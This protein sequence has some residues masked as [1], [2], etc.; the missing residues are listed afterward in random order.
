MSC[1]MAAEFSMLIVDVLVIIA[2]FTA[3]FISGDVL[4]T[5]GM[6]YSGDVSGTLI[7]KIHPYSWI[8]AAIILT[9]LFSGKN[10]WSAPGM[11]VRKVVIGQCIVLVIMIGV[12]L[13][14]GVQGVGYILDTIVAPS[15]L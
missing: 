12:G 4:N 10:P 14:K 15:A 2:V 5:A 8:C 7:E 3:T 9:L 13:L 11:R 6:N 1:F